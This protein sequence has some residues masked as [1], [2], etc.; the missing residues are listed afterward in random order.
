MNARACIKTSNPRPV[1]QEN[2]SHLKSTRSSPCASFAIEVG[3]DGFSKS[4]GIGLYRQKDINK[5]REDEPD[6][7]GVSLDGPMTP[8]IRFEYVGYVG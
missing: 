5:M 6:N 7:T 8:S 1:E 4:E 2:I 3:P